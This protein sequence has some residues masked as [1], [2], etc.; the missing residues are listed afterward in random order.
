[1]DM[2]C[3]TTRVPYWL[4]YCLHCNEEKQLSEHFW[5]GEKNK[6][7][8]LISTPPLV[9]GS[10]HFRQ[11]WP[12]QVALFLDILNE[13][14]DKRGVL[15]GFR[16]SVGQELDAVLAHSITFLQEREGSGPNE[17]RVHQQQVSILL[18]LWAQRGS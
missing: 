6:N 5:G 1:M 13:R 11:L 17:D 16:L 8:Y 14:V 7:M 12:Q 9:W 10:H 15:L 18:F 4:T 3:R 2:S